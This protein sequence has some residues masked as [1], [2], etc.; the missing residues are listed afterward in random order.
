MSAKEKPRLRHKFWIETQSGEGIMGEG[1]WHLN[2]K[3]E[4]DMDLVFQE[5]MDE[6]KDILK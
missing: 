5:M 4:D 6:L 1:K 2:T 3:T